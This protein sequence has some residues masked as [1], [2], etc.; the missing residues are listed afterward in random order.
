MRVPAIV[1]WPGRVPAG[2]TCD[3]LTTLMDFLPTFAALAGG[4]LPQRTIDGRNIWP[5]LSGQANAGTP[6]DA[7]FYY[8]GDQLQAVRSGPWKLYLALSRRRQGSGAA[9]AVPE[10]ARPDDDEA[11]SLDD[12]APRRT[13]AQELFGT[14]L[15]A[16]AA[17]AASAGGEIVRPETA[18]PR[19]LDLDLVA[20][21]YGEFDRRGQRF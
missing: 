3:Q 16:R 21:L 8:Q 13:L 17:A 19:R 12:T 5:L 9:N 2:T 15:E 20:R 11:G 6:H 18:A 14:A 7:F 1:R 10:P 4:T